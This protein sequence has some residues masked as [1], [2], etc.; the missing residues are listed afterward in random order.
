MAS[1][2]DKLSVV[3]CLGL[4]WLEVQISSSNEP[5][6]LGFLLSSDPVYWTSIQN[7]GVC[8]WNEMTDNFQHIYV[9]L[10]IYHCHKPFRLCTFSICS[11]QNMKVLSFSFKFSPVGHGK[12]IT[13]ALLHHA[14][15]RR[16]SL[17]FAYD[18]RSVVDSN[19]NC[20]YSLQ[21]DVWA[22]CWTNAFMSF[23]S[24]QSE[25]IVLINSLNL[26]NLLAWG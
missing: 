6:W 3:T 8:N 2:E 1:Y 7:I 9:S 20:L 22:F 26:Y 10:I 18:Y 13:N 5:K 4:L 12:T 11:F 19:R 14:F 23:V 17:L 16:H 15:P 21:G 25:Q 24:F